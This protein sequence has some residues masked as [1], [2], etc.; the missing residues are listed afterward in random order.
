MRAGISKILALQLQASHN[1]SGNSFVTN[2]KPIMHT[3]NATINSRV[4]NASPERLYEAFTNPEALAWWL[5]PAGMTGHIHHF[6]LRVGGG[7]DMSLFYPDQ[8]T[9]GKTAAGEDR[10]EARFVELTPYKRIIQDIRFN[11]TDPAFEG[12]MIMEVTFEPLGSSTK[13]TFHFTDIPPGIRP[14]DNEAGTVQ[15]LDK[16]EKYVSADR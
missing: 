10:F 8:E 7:Y 15:S 11:T 1:I 14:E 4:I 5:A 16:L 13:V 3:T 12:T 2:K 6:D 9:N